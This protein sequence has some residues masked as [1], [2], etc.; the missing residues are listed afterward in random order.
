MLY[1]CTC[2]FP[3]LGFD[4]LILGRCGRNKL[5]LPA[6][7]KSWEAS[8][9]TTSWHSL[10]DTLNLWK[11]IWIWCE[12]SSPNMDCHIVSS[13][14][15]F[16]MHKVNI[17][18]LI[19]FKDCHGLKYYSNMDAAGHAMLYQAAWMVFIE[20]MLQSSDSPR[21]IVVTVLELTDC[22]GQVS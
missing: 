13:L 14:H 11:K 9:K 15:T 10:N 7:S 3:S 4:L 5:E 6:L 12:P 16:W 2:L 22:K 20:K 21:R 1:L 17:C 8:R 18:L 19:V